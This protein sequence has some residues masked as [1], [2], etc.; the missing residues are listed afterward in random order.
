MIR[1]SVCL[2]VI[3]F[4]YWVHFQNF[5]RENT[6]LTLDNLM[7]SGSWKEGLIIADK[8]LKENPRSHRIWYMRA[9]FLLE[10]AVATGEKNH[11][12]N[13]NEAF[14]TAL[15][16]H[17][18]NPKYYYWKAQLA[19]LRAKLTM[20]SKYYR[21]YIETMYLT[22]S[23]DPNNYFYYS[24]FFEKVFSLFKDPGYLS[25]PLSRDLLMNSIQFSLE[26]YLRLKQFY[27]D[28]YLIEFSTLLRVSERETL[29]KRKDLNIQIRKILELY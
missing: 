2:L 25:A 11:W 6:Y 14:N 3:G 10:A 20:N 28:R 9:R 27:A 15:K 4:L 18:K 5:N 22:C 7:H 26:N 19:F 16:L 23:L 13:A 17:N 8:W 1:L 29:L 12:Q 24:V 21:E